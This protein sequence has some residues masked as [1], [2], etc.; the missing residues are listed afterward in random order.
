[1]K[2]LIL[3]L[4]FS[5][6]LINVGFGQAAW[7]NP[8]YK[9]SPYRKIL[10]IAKIQDPISKRQLEDATSLKL[11]SKG[12]PAVA[13]YSVI[14]AADTLSDEGF[15]RA[16]DSLKIDG[17]LVFD[18]SP[19]GKV[20]TRKPTISLG[21]GI[22]FRLGIF[23]GAIGTSVPLAGGTNL[24]PFISGT[25]SFYN[26]SSK[27]MQWSNPFGGSPE[28]GTKVLY[29]KVARVTIR[30]MFRDQIFIR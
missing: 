18:I 29:D 23:G 15:N 30:E 8:V 14:P 7:R 25:A 12:I 3:F 5:L 27:D 26:R 22:P 28:N 20:I 1:M 13:E 17:L 16:A 11:N 24:N 9:A 21:I 19:P 4:G 6:S 10:V 2:F